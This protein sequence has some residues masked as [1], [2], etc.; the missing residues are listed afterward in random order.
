VNNKISIAQ[1]AAAGGLAG[2]KSSAS[3]ND[4]RGIAEAAFAAQGK[5]LVVSKVVKAGQSKAEASQKP[6]KRKPAAPKPPTEHEEQ[7]SLIQWAESQSARLPA[8]RMLFAIPNGA[9]LPYRKVTAKGVAISHERRK[10]LAEG[11]RPGVPDAFL[12][13]PSNGQNGLFIEMKRAQKS[14]S[15]TSPEQLSWHSALSAMGYRVEVCYGC[16]AAKNAI[17]NYLE[18]K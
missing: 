17:L 9:K 13:C 10:M 16:E 3:G 15:K 7:V 4:L 8:L 6:R 2:L 11:M 14:L 12:A 1:R 18:G 5:P